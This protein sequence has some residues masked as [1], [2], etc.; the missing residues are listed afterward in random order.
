MPNTGAARSG[1]ELSLAGSMSRSYQAADVSVV[2]QARRLM[3][4]NQLMNTYA[5]R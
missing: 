3:R 4:K 5:A 1:Q 2:L